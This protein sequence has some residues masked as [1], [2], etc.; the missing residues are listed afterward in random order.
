MQQI[1]SPLSVSFQ[2]NKGPGGSMS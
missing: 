2:N 1:T